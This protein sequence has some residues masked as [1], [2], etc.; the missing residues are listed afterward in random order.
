MPV[1]SN[2]VCDI[3]E[4]D[5]EAQLSEEGVQFGNLRIASLLFADDMVLLASSNHD[6]QHALRRF[7]AECETSG[8]KVSTSKSK[9]R[10]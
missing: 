2:P 5:P 3:Q 7:A 6:L 10:K 4:W 1:V 8:M 9:A